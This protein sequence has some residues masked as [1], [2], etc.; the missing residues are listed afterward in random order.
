M[1]AIGHGGSLSPGVAGRAS[2]STAVFGSPWPRFYVPDV[3]PRPVATFL[4]E[5]R[6]RGTGGSSE[7]VDKGRDIT[8]RQME[9]KQREKMLLLPS[10]LRIF[11]SEL[12]VFKSPSSNQSLAASMLPYAV[13]YREMRLKIG[14]ADQSRLLHKI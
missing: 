12:C 9:R 13:S 5:G 8:L 14:C 6:F 11:P 1:G 10:A 3:A 7:I 4:L 2:P